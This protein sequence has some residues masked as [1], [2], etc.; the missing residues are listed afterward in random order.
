MAPPLPPSAV[1]GL[2]L[3]LASLAATRPGEGAG[4]AP[5]PGGGA[6][7]GACRNDS[8][9]RCPMHLGSLD[10]LWGH[11]SDKSCRVCPLCRQGSDP[12]VG[13]VT[14]KRTS[15]T[16]ARPLASPHAPRT[17]L[18]R[19][20]GSPPPVVGPRAERAAATSHGRRRAATVAPCKPPAAAANNQ[21]RRPS[22]LGSAKPRP[23]AV[24][25][26]RRGGTCLQTRDT[27]VGDPAGVSCILSACWSGKPT[28]GTSP[29]SG[30][31]IARSSPRARRSPIRP[32]SARS[33]AATG[34][35]CPRRTARSLLST[36]PEGCWARR[37]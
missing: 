1:R 35:S 20:A 6:V 5:L 28:P 27:C 8:P 37:R 3:L 12:K 14:P 32:I 34:G 23:A 17:G 25:R 33:R 11:S 21:L 30:P 36:K 16:A 19:P 7:G 15:P 26:Q 24:L 9:G 13:R 22:P 29:P 31:A 10:L 4:G 2:L 18:R